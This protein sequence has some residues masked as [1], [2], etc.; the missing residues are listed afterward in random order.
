MLR[1]LT[2]E[3]E[4]S[5]RRTSW[6]AVIS[7]LNTPTGTFNSRLTC[8]AMFMAREVLPTDGRAAMTIISPSCKPV[9]ILS[10]SAKPVEMP[11]SM[12]MGLVILFDL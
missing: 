1:K 7:R 3:R 9:V 4:H 12:P 5:M 8:S 6:S 2:R 10:K 11:V